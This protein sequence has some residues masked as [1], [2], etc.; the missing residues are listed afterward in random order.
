MEFKLTREEFLDHFES[1]TEEM[2]KICR[3]K[4][5]DYTGATDDPFAN[6]SRVEALGICSTET[7]FLT[8]MTDKLCRISSFVANGTLKVKD[9]SVD[10]TLIDLA[11]YS[12]LFLCYRESKRDDSSRKETP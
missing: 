4:N 5:A 1:V 6:F 7:G 9:E 10:D 12:I 2:V 11:C 3:A 8:R